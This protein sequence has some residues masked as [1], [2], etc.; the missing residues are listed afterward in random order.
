MDA[1]RSILHLHF[2]K[3]TLRNTSIKNLQGHTS[4]PTVKVRLN[5]LAQKYLDSSLVTSNSLI[6]RCLDEYTNLFLADPSVP[7]KLIRTLFDN[8]IHSPK[9]ST[10]GDNLNGQFLI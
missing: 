1:F 7:Y 5:E 3:H 9:L 6:M 10:R 4:M 8:W 2:D